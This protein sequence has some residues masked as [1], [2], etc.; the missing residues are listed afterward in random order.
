MSKF[1][2]RFNNLILEENL[3]LRKL[4]KLIQISSS[5]LSKYVSGNFEPSL[6]NSIKISNYFKCSIDYLFGLDDDRY[7]YDI[8]RDAD[9]DKFIE[10][11]LLLINDREININRISKNTYINRSCIYNWKNSKIFPKVGLLA[12]LATELDSSIEYLIGRCDVK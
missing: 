12:S 5:Q 9:I 6:N 10:R 4:S 3:S 7:N 2:E 11:L 1:V 8:V